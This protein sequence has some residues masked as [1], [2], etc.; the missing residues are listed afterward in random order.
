[1]GA[2]QFT[3]AADPASPTVFEVPGET[4]PA[5]KYINFYGSGHIVGTCCMG[6]TKD[7]SVVDRA[8]TCVPGIHKNMFIVAA[9]RCSRTGRHRQS[10]LLTIAAL[11]LRAAAT[12]LKTDLKGA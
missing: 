11:A 1:M 2:T 6:T 4:D 12:I 5:R 10:E 3:T 9:A 8:N 7:N